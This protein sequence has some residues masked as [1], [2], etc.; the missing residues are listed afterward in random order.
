MGILHLN[1]E[2]KNTG[3]NTVVKVTTFIQWISIDFSINHS[4]PSFCSCIPS[5]WIACIFTVKK[6][7]EY[8]YLAAL[9]DLKKCSS[10]NITQRS[11]TQEGFYMGTYSMV[12]LSS[13]FYATYIWPGRDADKRHKFSSHVLLASKLLRK[14]KKGTKTLWKE[15]KRTPSSKQNI[16]GISEII[17]RLF[18]DSLQ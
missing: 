16:L 14:W 2:G 5:F 3:Y 17:V 10:F 18:R 1:K 4:F 13:S 12:R 11:V 15:K 7:N 8:I 6:I 9:G